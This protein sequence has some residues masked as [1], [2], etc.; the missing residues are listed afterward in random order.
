MNIEYIYNIYYYLSN[1]T[2]HIYIYYKL[3][4]YVDPDPLEPDNFAP[5]IRQGGKFLL[6]FDFSPRH[7]FHGELSSSFTCKFVPQGNILRL[8]IIR[9]KIPI[10]HFTKEH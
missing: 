4:R 1:I 9:C 8:S 7:N 6:R 10:F 2:E 5:W 3:N